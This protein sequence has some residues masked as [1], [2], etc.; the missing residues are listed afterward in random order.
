MPPGVVIVTLPV[1]VPGGTVVVAVVAV[2]TL[3]VAAAVP[4]K[5]PP[6]VPLRFVP[7]RV[8]RRVP[9]KP[10]VG[11][12]RRQPLRYAAVGSTLPLRPPLKQPSL[13]AGWNK[14]NATNPAAPGSYILLRRSLFSRG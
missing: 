3:N 6:V 7:V 10:L 8:T 5:R 1:V 11:L 4:L 9:T 14:L 12:R 2:R 13:G